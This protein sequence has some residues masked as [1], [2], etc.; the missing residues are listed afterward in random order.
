ME[1]KIAFIEPLIERFDAYGKASFALIKLRLVEKTAGVFS[2]FIARCVVV[3]VFSMF[4][5]S[6]NI[7]VALWLGDLLGKTYYGFFC[8][9][10]FYG[11]IGLILYFFL[12]N[13]MKKQLNNSIIL[14]ML[15]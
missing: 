12:N 10:G 3:I 4:V 9:A 6:L 15:N 14:Q 2:T 1:D 13:W 5:V 8:V 7:G 11:L